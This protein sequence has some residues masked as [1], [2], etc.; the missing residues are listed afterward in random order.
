MRLSRFEYRRRTDGRTRGRAGEVGV[1][2]TAAAAA[3]S[4]VK[5]PTAA[6]A[7]AMKNHATNVFQF[8]TK[9]GRDSVARQLCDIFYP[10]GM[11]KITN[12]S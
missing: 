1:S 7:V 5:L 4:K 10:G 9:Q 6:A 2:E 12:L 3:V 11:Y 8:P